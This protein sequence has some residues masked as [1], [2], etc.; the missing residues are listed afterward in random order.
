MR[1]DE[2]ETPGSSPAA[3]RPSRMKY[4]AL[5]RRAIRS[6]R[7]KASTPLTARSSQSRCVRGSDKPR[8]AIIVQSMATAITEPDAGKCQRR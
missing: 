8:N 6:S 5:P 4:I 2:T 1:D 7:L 3:V